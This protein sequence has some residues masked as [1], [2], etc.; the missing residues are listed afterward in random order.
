MILM[1]Q[2]GCDALMLPNK[3]ISLIKNALFAQP[4]SA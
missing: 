3:L 1:R 4:V 2:I